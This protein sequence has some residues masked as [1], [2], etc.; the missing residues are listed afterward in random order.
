M[1]G[2]EQHALIVTDVHRERDVHG[3]KDDGVVE[4]Y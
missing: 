1:T 4:R 2:D 3:G